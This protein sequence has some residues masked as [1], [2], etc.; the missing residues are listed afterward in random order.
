TVL[1]Y[2]NKIELFPSNIIANL[3]GFKAAQ[4]FEVADEAQREAP[5]V[6]F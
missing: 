4:F 1:G 3:F 2:N 5:K 6:K